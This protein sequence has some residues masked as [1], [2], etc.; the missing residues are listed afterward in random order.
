MRRWRG[1]PWFR[2]ILRRGRVQ[3]RAILTH[4]LTP[5]WGSRLGVASSCLSPL[6]VASDAQVE[7]GSMAPTHPSNW[8]CSRRAL[9]AHRLTPWWGSLDWPVWSGSRVG[10]VS[11]RIG[12]TRGSPGATAWCFAFGLG[13]SP[14]EDVVAWAAGRSPRWLLVLLPRALLFQEEPLWSPYTSLW[15]GRRRHHLGDTGAESSRRHLD[16]TCGCVVL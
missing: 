14:S 1:G 16:A 7:G 4:R 10:P 5:W 11:P 15:R 6:V 3:E 12:S 8:A 9:S 13:A 2:P